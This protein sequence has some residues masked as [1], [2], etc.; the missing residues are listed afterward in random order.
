MFKN[1]VAVLSFVFLGFA[2]KNYLKHTTRTNWGTILYSVLLGTVISQ[3]QTEYLIW[4]IDKNT[5]KMVDRG[6]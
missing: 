4:R 1:L 5:E 3:I 2:F 6:E